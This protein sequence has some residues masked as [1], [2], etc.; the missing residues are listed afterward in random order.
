MFGNASV[1]PTRPRVLGNRESADSGVFFVVNGKGPAHMVHR[2]FSVTHNQRRSD[3]FA[4][5]PAAGA[6][7]VAVAGRTVV[8]SMSGVGRPSF[9]MASST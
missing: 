5:S 2:P 6:P 3:Y 4:E 8:V 9:G 7:A 1:N